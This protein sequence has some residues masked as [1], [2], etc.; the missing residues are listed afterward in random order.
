M[1]KLVLS[2]ITIGFSLYVQAQDTIIKSTRLDSLIFAGINSYR[3]SLGVPAIKT[4]SYGEIR[5]ISYALTE[6]NSNRQF[7]EHTSGSKI[8]VGYNSE[9]IFRYTTTA[10]SNI[11]DQ[12]L[13]N[14]ADKAVQTWIASPNHNWIIGCSLANECTVTT[15]IKKRGKTISV[16]ASYHAKNKRIN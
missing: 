1:K 11:S 5:K 2:F 15:V 12:D 8:F 3:T 16:T 10:S 13:Q 6:A 9:C 14:F 7:I 4:F